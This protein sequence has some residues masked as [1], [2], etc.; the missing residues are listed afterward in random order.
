MEP[1]CDLNIKQAIH[2]NIIQLLISHY[3]ATQV[4]YIH[5]TYS[6]ISPIVPFVQIE[7]DDWWRISL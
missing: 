5:E 2:C 7:E 3:C 4:K 1:D 6:V